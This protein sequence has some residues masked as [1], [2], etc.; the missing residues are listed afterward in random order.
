[1]SLTKTILI[2]AMCFCILL[3]IILAL[4]NRLSSS[5]STDSTFSK[6]VGVFTVLGVIF[7]IVYSAFTPPRS[8]EIFPKKLYSDKEIVISIDSPDDA[9]IYYELE[10]SRIPTSNSTKYTE[11]FTIYQSSS[12]IAVA[13]DYLNAV[14]DP[15]TVIYS[16]GSTSP[17]TTSTQLSVGSQP[18]TPSNPVSLRN[19]L[20]GFSMPNPKYDILNQ[21]SFNVYTG[22]GES[23]IRGANGNAIVDTKEEIQLLGSKY[24]WTLIA[25]EI[26]SGTA[27]GKWRIGYIDGIFD[28]RDLPNANISAKCV[29]DTYLT[30]IHDV[31]ANVIMYLAKDTEVIV[32]AADSS[33]AYV[34]YPRGSAWGYVPLDALE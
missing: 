29:V 26:T 23:Y 28:Q 15:S 31:T 13:I 25:Y 19:R 4:R 18:P 5:K 30:D 27:S 7:T 17:P 22:P 9:S 14:S 34:Q 1:M 12:I 6:V 32:M 8:P 3:I 20:V 16:I 2:G 21:G 11:P 24:G 10:D 33:W